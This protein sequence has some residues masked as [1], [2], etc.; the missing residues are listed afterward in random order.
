M[1]M[2]DKARCLMIL[3]PGAGDRGFA[4]RDEGFV[5]AL[6]KS[7]VSVD[8]VA[9]NATMGYYFKGIASQR[10][11]EDV[12]APARRVGYEQVWLLGISMGGFG[13][14][15]YGQRHSEEIDGIFAL[16]PYLG[17][18]SMGDEIRESGGLKKWRPD[19]PAPITE[20]NYLRQMW[21][22]LQRVV[23][24]KEK[25]PTIYLG[26]GDQDGLGPQDSVLGQAL[27]KGHVFHS[28]GA[29]EWAP[30][31]DMLQQFLQASEFR[32][33]CADR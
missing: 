19:F 8:L 24:G 26:Y 18:S 1:P 27:P 17:S 11:E 15:E 31:R 28:P 5:D 30:W 21:S 2:R 3:L 20:D 22:W 7:G 25:G 6:Q 4:Y 16:A 23:S 10:L 32:T 14:F 9:A 33:R 12:I 13:V 29:H